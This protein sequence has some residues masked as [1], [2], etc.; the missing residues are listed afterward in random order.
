MFPAAALVKRL[1][2][3][4]G[5]A[6]AAA[7]GALA[8]LAAILTSGL[9]PLI[10]SQF[11]AGGCWG[12]ASVAA[13]SAVIGFGRTGKE[14]RYLGALFAALAVAAFARIAAYASDVIIEPQLKAL[15]P[16]IP[17]AAW[18]LSAALLYLAARSFRRS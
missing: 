1:G 8:I 11:V 15:L 6:I 18:L 10:A 7:V 3:L 14:G 9:A 12:A 2:A 17:E 13:Y 5:M 16:W 4:N